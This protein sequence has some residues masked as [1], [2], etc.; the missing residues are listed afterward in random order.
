[1]NSL[2]LGTEKENQTGL[3]KGRVELSR[4]R[5]ALRSRYL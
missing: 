3:G 2:S 5:A 1:M 4:A